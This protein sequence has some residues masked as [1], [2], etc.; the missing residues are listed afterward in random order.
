[1]SRK[2]A[3]RQTEEVLFI[4]MVFSKLASALFLS[5]LINQLVKKKTTGAVQPKKKTMRQ[6]WPVWK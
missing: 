5:I 6:N 4:R 3:L 1:M 2:A